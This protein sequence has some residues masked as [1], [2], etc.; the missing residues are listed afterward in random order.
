MVD[1]SRRPEYEHSDA[2]PALVGV[3]AFGLA[4]FLILTPYALHWIYPSAAQQS[5]ITHLPPAPPAPRL[6]ID[7]AADLRAYRHSEDEK[8]MTYGWANRSQSVV[9]I[10]IER[11][12]DLI[13]ERG[14]PGWSR[15]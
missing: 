5:K 10:P 1:A 2:S 15:P 3:L 7:P 14:L 13:A 9:R 11:A 8:L 6:Q 12:K 4:G